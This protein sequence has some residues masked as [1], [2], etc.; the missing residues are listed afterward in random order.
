ML[1]R[2]ALVLLLLLTPAAAAQDLDKATSAIVQIS[3]KRN[4]ATV[5][6]SGFVVG[7]APHKATIVTA[8]HVIEGVEQLQVT[9]AAD[10][11]ESFSAGAVLGMEMGNPRGL[12]VFQVR[13][14]LPV[15][16]TTLSFETE[17]QLRRGEEVFLLGFPEMARTPL[18]LRRTFAGPDGNFL[19]L[20]LP[21]GEGISGAPVLRNSG[22]V[23][24]VVVEV[25]GG[26]A[27]AVKALVA[28]DAVLGWGGSL[29]SQ[30]GTSPS[31]PPSV[32]AACV[33]A[34]QIAW[35]ASLTS[36]S[37]QEPSPWARPPATRRPTPT[38]SRRTR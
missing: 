12:A 38:R 20:D 16:M 1:K 6:G 28:R 34:G 23:L 36:A 11:T 4:G 8:S 3:G 30:G 31:P 7:L 21:A 33:P 24:G 13:G 25:D 5:R 37:A 32:A 14:D 26:I 17:S 9:F 19:Q 15:G 35:T 27:F 10:R 29:G 22:G 18:A 2:T